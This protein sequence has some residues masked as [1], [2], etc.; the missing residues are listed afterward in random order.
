MS[1]VKKTVVEKALANF[2]EEMNY[3]L[4]ADTKSLVI[5]FRVFYV[6]LETDEIVKNVMSAC[7]PEDMKENEWAADIVIE[8]P[9]EGYGAWVLI[10]EIPKTEDI[11]HIGFLYNTRP[12][13]PVVCSCADESPG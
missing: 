10:A 4:E 9:P 6:L 11:N 12:E 7:L 1:N 2:Q 8:Y 5:G 3:V 13:A